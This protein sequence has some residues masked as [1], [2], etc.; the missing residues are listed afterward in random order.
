MPTPDRG[1]Y[2]ILRRGGDVLIVCQKTPWWPQPFWSFPGGTADPGETPLVAMA[3]EVHEETGLIVTE[4][5]A[6]AWQLHIEREPEHRDLEISFFEVAAFTGEV[7]V[8]DPA[9]VVTEARWVTPPQAI[10]LLSLETTPQIV[11]PTLDYLTHGTVRR[12]QW[13]FRNWV[14]GVSAELVETTPQ[15]V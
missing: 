15:T 2:G 1:A 6:L 3:R 9:G 11:R 8:D 4:P 12:P 7:V 10:S 5:G 13:R 14:P